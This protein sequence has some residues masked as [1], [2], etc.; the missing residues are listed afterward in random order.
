MTDRMRF[1]G[2]H[3]LVSGGAN[4][5]GAAAVRLF[6]AEG[7]RV[8]IVDRDDSAA[9]TLVA[10]M[11]AAGHTCRAISCDLAV[12]AQ[13]EN[14]V[15]LALDFGGPVDVL[16]NHA[17]GLLIAAF[18]RITLSDWKA[19]FDRNVHSMF[20]M[21]QQVLVGMLA[22]GRGV[23][24]NTGSI[25][26]DLATPYEAAYCTTKAA[27]HM[28]T[29]AIATEYRD[30]GIRANAVAPGFILTAHG[31]KELLALRELSVDMS[32][33]DIIDMQGRMCT[34]DEVARTVAF[35]ASDEASFINGEI[36]RVDNGLS[37]RT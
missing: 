37:V 31:E 34:P 9:A 32:E 23:I 26:A 28:L 11:S 3:V 36:V 27:C 19:L 33:Q 5:V 12:P 21:S 10:E 4:G 17:G 15:A 6:A 18:D 13:I 35:L 29:K 8:S 14:A 1:E 2:T 25:S 20:L 7:A 24:V 22:T 16:F 30:K